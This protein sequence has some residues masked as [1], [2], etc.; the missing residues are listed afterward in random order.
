MNRLTR[1]MLVAMAVPTVFTFAYPAHGQTFFPTI[2]QFWSI[3]QNAFADSASPS[4][5]EGEG[6]L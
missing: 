1:I 2:G 4:P 6:V 5:I 3:S